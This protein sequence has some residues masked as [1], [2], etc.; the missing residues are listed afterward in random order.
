VR[1]ESSNTL[2][3]TMHTRRGG[4]GE[5]MGQISCHENLIIFIST[6]CSHLFFL[7]H[8]RILF[9]GGHTCY[10]RRPFDHL[11]LSHGNGDGGRKQEGIGMGIPLLF[12]SYEHLCF[13][14]AGWVA[15][16]TF[17]T[18]RACALKGGSSP[19]GGKTASEASAEK[20]RGRGG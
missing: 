13:M 4:A 11:S 17:Y 3:D 15:I 19:E 16:C 7:F 20:G 10:N 9:R 8:L 18:A 5:R 6:C 14:G 1:R 2:S 12:P